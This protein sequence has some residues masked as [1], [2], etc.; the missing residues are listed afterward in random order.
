MAYKQV[1]LEVY[2]SFDYRG[3]K[4]AKEPE[5]CKYGV[6]NPGYHCFENHCSFKNYTKCPNEFSYAGE[7]GEV[8]D[9]GSYIGFGGEMEPDDNDEAKRRKLIKLWERICIKKIDEAYE[10]YLFKKN[11]VDNN[12]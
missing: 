12:L 4:K 1:L 5:F 2:C 11:K 9:G 3:D 8:R 10:E 6:N 7:L